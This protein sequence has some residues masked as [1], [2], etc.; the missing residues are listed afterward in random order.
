MFYTSKYFG[1]SCGSRGY[2]DRE[3]AGL[4]WTVC[5]TVRFFAQSLICR[6]LRAA[7]NACRDRKGGIFLELSTEWLKIKIAEVIY[8]IISHKSA[9]GSRLNNG[10]LIED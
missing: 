5:F 4:V 9:M 2:R 3:A 7:L 8:G 1:S 6:Y 10:S